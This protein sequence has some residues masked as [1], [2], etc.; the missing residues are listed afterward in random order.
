MPA[1]FQLGMLFAFVP[2]EIASGGVGTMYSQII[3]TQ[4]IVV[5]AVFLG[6][7]LIVLMILRRKGGA[8]RASLKAGKRISV[9]E[10]TAVSPTERVRLISVDDSEFLMLS[11]KG[12]APVL[13]PLTA[14]STVADLVSA[15]S[16]MGL[17]DIDAPQMDA[18]TPS[19][20]QTEGD[21]LYP[22]PAERAAF[23]EKFQSWRRDHAAG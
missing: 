19:A 15:P 4:Q 22:S 7:M 3:G 1:V 5:T 14:A 17:A 8:I 11:A 6:V 21:R 9:I 12:Q 13:M 20:A 2:A 23:I 16:S 18:S 10:D